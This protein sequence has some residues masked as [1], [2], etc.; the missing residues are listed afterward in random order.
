MSLGPA[1]SAIR[2]RVATQFTAC[3]WAWANERFAEPVDE[4]GKPLDANGAR[5]PFVK[6][7]VLGGLNDMITTGAPDGSGTYRH[8]GLIRGYVVVPF[9]T[10]TDEAMRVADAFGAVFAYAEMGTTVRTYAPST[11][12]NVAGYEDGNDYVLMVSI[13]FDYIYI[14]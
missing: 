2:D 9:G 1:V 10:S 12:A 13:P 8:P 5:V 14:A 7:E 3:R 6:V 4:G 11:F